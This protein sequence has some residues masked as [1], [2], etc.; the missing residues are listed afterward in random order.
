M[1]IELDATRFSEGVGDF[2][3]GHILTDAEG[4]EIEIV[5]FSGFAE[6]RR[7]KRHGTRDD[8]RAFL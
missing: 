7:N 2:D 6:I 3:I 1:M 5:K 8:Q 4:S